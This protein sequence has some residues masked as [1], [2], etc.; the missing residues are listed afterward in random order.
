[1]AAL[2]IINGL[3]IGGPL[4][5]LSPFDWT[6]DHI[7]LVGIY[8]WPAVALEGILGVP[9]TELFR[10]SVR[11]YFANG[12]PI[13]NEALVS[14]FDAD[15]GQAITQRPLFFSK[16]PEMIRTLYSGL[17]GGMDM[18][19]WQVISRSSRDARCR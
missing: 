1:M 3:S 8:D 13:Q 7:P 19:W 9:A 2:W 5:L 10:H 16:D 14:Y 18:S 6:F 11:V 15:S 17:G 12:I 4:M